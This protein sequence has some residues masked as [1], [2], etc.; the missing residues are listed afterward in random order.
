MKSKERK[1]IMENTK[2][3]DKVLEKAQSLQKKVQNNIRDASDVFHNKQGELFELQDAIDLLAGELKVS[4]KVAERLIEG[5]VGD[6]VDPIVMISDED[7]RYVGIVEY[8]EFEYAYGYVDYHDKY[9]RGKR[10]ICSEC[11]NEVEEDME[12]KFAASNDPTGSFFGEHNYDVLY[13]GVK[14]HLRKDHGITFGNN[15]D[16]SDP[17]TGATLV[18]GTTVGG[19]TAWHDGNADPKARSAIEG[20]NVNYVNFSNHEHGDYDTDGRLYWDLSAGLYIKSSNSDH[21]QTGGSLLWSSENFTAGRNINVSYDGEDHP[22]LSIPEY[23][24]NR[25]GDRIGV[26]VYAT[27]SDLP[28]GNEGDIAY[29]SDTGELYVNDGT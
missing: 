16:V 14:D 24:D 11:V 6:D 7:T 13:E 25:N 5:L 19:N 4:E 21:P 29:V 17:E 15:E 18:S 9:G 26:P 12:V 2:D 28:A 27:E 22:T 10:V 20:G 3:P 8:K 23:I 1:K